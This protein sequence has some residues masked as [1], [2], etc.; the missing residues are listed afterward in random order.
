MAIWHLAVS[1]CPEQIGL[2]DDDVCLHRLSVHTHVSTEFM[3]SSDRLM[4]AYPQQSLYSCRTP[5][6][7]L[8]ELLAPIIK[9]NKFVFIECSTLDVNAAHIDLNETSHNDV[10]DDAHYHVLQ[11][12]NHKQQF[13][14]FS[15]VSSD[16]FMINTGLN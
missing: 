1:S 4:L 2:D 6:N 3:F 12:K 16:L 11:I 14:V 5:V 10:Y 8:I 13:Y 9:V 15:G 7:G